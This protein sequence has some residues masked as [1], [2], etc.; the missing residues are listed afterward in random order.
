MLKPEALK[1]RV[2]TLEVALISFARSLKLPFKFS[3]LSL[4]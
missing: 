4:Y 3:R 1:V 2:A